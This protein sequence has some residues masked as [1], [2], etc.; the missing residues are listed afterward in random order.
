VRCE[1]PKLES[2]PVVLP[3]TV[4]SRRRVTLQGA[5]QYDRPDS[6]KKEEVLF[7]GFVRRAMVK[8]SDVSEKKFASIFSVTD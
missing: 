5:W 2:Y 4:S 7:S 6:L 1:F 3:G 8:C